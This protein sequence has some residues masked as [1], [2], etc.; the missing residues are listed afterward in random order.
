LYSKKPASIPKSIER[1]ELNREEKPSLSSLKESEVSR[2]KKDGNRR[3][4]SSSEPV[5]SK[6]AGNIQQSKPANTEADLKKKAPDRRKTS[7]E[8]DKEREIPFAAAKETP[9]GHTPAEAKTDSIVA[10][11]PNRVY[12]LSELPSSVSQKLPAFS[13][14]VFLYSDDPVARM[15]RVNGQMIKEGQYL[16]PGLKLEQIIPSGA[17]FSYQN[18]RFLVGPK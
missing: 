7:I 15:V 8:T 4:M 13:L 2:E 14:S 5:V 16:S 6:D 12:N 18:F 9:S 11:V 3:E 10:P 17:I 1:S